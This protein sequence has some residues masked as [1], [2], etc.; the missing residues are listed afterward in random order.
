MDRGV[1]WTASRYVYWLIRTSRE[2]RAFQMAPGSGGDGGGE[3]PIFQWH[4]N[5][6]RETLCQLMGILPTGQRPS[7]IGDIRPPVVKI[8]KLHIDANDF[9]FGQDMFSAQEGGAHVDAIERHY[10]EFIVR[11][12]PLAHGPMDYRRRSGERALWQGIPSCGGEV[13]EEVVVRRRAAMVNHCACE[14]V[15]RSCSS[16]VTLRKLPYWPPE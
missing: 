12:S 16:A 9:A 5:E 6:I 1:A 2:E 14:P 13:D 10:H 8:P 4:Q 7:G 11:R 3:K 15:S